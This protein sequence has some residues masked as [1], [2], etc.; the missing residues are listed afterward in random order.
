MENIVATLSVEDVKLLLN[1]PKEK[2]L[3]DFTLTEITTELTRRSGSKFEVRKNSMMVDPRMGMPIGYAI[4][5]G[6]LKEGD[7]SIKFTVITT[8][9]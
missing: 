9:K 2:T 6:E 7:V 8:E 3:K 1:P 4:A 5:N